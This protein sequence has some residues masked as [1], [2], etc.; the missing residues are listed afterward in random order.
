MTI[1]VV[2]IHALQSLEQ[3]KAF[4]ETVKSD[5]AFWK[6]LELVLNLIEIAKDWL[7][8]RRYSINAMRSDEDWNGSQMVERSG[9]P[10]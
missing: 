7:Y 2:A 4:L 6:S 5:T 9:A 8:R 1:R 10:A 3:L